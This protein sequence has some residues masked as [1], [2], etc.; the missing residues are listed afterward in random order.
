MN[1]SSEEAARSLR[2]IEASRLA[3]QSVIRAHRGHLYLWIWGTVWIAVSLLLWVDAPRFFVLTNWISVGGLVATAGF[4]L[5]QRR[6][7]RS[8][9]DNRF[10]AVCAILLAFGYGVWPVFLGPPHSY[11]AAYGFGILIWMQIY[12]VAGIWFDSY[13]LWIGLAMTVLILAGFLLFPA[14]FWAGPLLGGI[15]LVGTGLYVRRFWE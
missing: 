3:M 6:Q 10:L 4:I 1:I 8:P 11:K 7:V 14:W 13:W 5:V 12:M 2:E 15:T 9:V